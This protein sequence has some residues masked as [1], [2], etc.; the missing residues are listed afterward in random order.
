M[1]FFVFFRIPSENIRIDS[2]F[3]IAT[4]PVVCIQQIFKNYLKIKMRIQ[5]I[6]K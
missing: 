5:R 1:G 4:T 6:R 3:K 2:T